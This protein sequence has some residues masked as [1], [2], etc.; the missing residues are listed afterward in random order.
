[1]PFLHPTYI[2]AILVAIA[3]HE[4]AHAF[5]AHLLGDDTAKW[6]GRLTVN[7]LAHI[8]PLGALLFLTVGFGWAK[9]VPVNPL[10]LKHP[11]RDMAIIAVAG[12]VSNLVLA[13]V[14]YAG[15]VLM[16]GAHPS[17]FG[18]VVTG[19]L[20]EQSVGEKMLELILLSSVMVNLGLMAFNLLPIPPLDGSNILRMFIPWQ[21]EARYLEWMRRA[22]MILLAIIVLESFT[23]IRILSGFVSAM[24]SATLALFSAVL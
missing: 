1:M 6:E 19:L 24:V 8:D 9:P 22:P 15:L 4:W 14:A 20:G 13:F 5:S 18:D 10:Q 11:K 2:I 12:P 17:S 7:P 16:Y 21:M 23:S 3:I